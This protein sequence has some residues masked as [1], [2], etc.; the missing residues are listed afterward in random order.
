MYDP[1]GHT[2]RMLRAVLR[3]GLH[4]AR[5]SCCCARAVVSAARPWALLSLCVRCCWSDE[6][7]WFRLV[8]LALLH[9]WV[10]TSWNSAAFPEVCMVL[11]EGRMG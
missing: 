9:A 7:L 6:T 5:S 4:W 2:P 1:C 8:D 11:V 10:W 3:L